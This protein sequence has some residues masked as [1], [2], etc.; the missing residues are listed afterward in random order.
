MWQNREL[1]MCHSKTVIQRLVKGWSKTI[2]LTGIDI[3]IY[4]VDKPIFL[5]DTR[6]YFVKH[7]DVREV[8]ENR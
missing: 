7:K 4:Y 5:V 8:Y 3:L 1:V 6:L 2:G